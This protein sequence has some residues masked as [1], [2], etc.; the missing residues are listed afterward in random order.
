[1]TRDEQDQGSCGE[2][3]PPNSACTECCYYW[4]RMIAEGYW[5]G[6]QW[7]EKGWREITK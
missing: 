1:M 3:C 2:P 4:Q 6:C 5:D 7:T